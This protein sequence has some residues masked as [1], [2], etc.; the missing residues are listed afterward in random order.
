M[1]PVTIAPV[2][3]NAAERARLAALPIHVCQHDAG[4][5]EGELG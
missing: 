5:R 2:P 1:N 4:L 3:S